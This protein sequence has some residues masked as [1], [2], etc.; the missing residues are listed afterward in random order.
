MSTKETNNKPKKKI[1]IHEKHRQRMKQKFL[2]GNIA[3]LADHELLEILLY[4]SIKQANTNPTAHNLINQF[5]N[6]LNMFKSNINQ[7]T[8]VAG[9]GE[10]SA[11]LIKLAYE[12][13]Q[14]AANPIR[15]KKEYVKSLSTAEQ[16]LNN[17]YKKDGNEQL[18]VA[19]LA[20]D[21]F[22][23]NTYSVSG[24]GMSKVEVQLR[25][26]TNF[27]LNNNC[28]RVLI[29]H[30]HPYAK[31]YPS[32]EDIAMTHRLLNSCILNDVDVIDHII[33]SP[34]G[35]YS[36]TASGLMEQVKE[37]V[38][39]MLHRT[40]GGK[41][42]RMFCCNTEKYTINRKP[43]ENETNGPDKLEFLKQMEDYDVEDQKNSSYTLN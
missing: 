24:G 11:L 40:K 23:L 5:G 26:I 43:N 34:E 19:C 27:I 25:T 41:D 16:F 10:S 29:S 22:V 9:I 20:P 35:N 2:E 7:L 13:G 17:N 14:R 1:N 37:D 4:Y 36:F 6:L 31:P 21:G 42:Y 18:I 28:E 39:Q 33:V 3:T 32:D 38:C 30:N 12:L 8:H 15:K